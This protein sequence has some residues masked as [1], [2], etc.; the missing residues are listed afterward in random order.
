MP[1][2]GVSASPKPA[3]IETLMMP[4][5]RSISRARSISQ[6]I[7]GLISASGASVIDI[8]PDLIRIGGL[9]AATTGCSSPRRMRSRISAPSTPRS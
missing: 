3:A 8:S 9:L 6:N 7:G 4:G 5:S 1:D 2:I